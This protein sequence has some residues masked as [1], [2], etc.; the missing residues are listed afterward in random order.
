MNFIYSFLNLWYYKK[1]YEGNT[2]IGQE[3]FPILKKEKEEEIL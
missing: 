1:T 3:V 2:S